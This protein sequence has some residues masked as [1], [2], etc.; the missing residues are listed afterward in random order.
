MSTWLILLIVVVLVAA[1]L[2]YYRSRRNH[3]DEVVGSA[4]NTRDYV[5]EREDSH[6]SRMSDEDRAWQ[7]ASLEKN[8]ENQERHPP[9][10]S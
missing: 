3:R 2:Y 9:T 5:Q 1:G 10:A 8:R 6:N 7:A 4:S